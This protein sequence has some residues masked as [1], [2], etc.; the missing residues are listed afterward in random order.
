M[1][2]QESLT[3]HSVCVTRNW[4]KEGAFHLKFMHFLNPDSV[5]FDTLASRNPY[6]SY[7]PGT[8]IPVF[9]FVK[10]S[11]AH[12]LIRLYET[13]NLLN[14]LVISLVLFLMMFMVVSYFKKTSIVNV[15]FSVIPSLIYLFT[16]PTLYWHQ[17]VFFADQAVMML[18]VLF[19]YLELRRFIYGKL[20]WPLEAFSVGLVFLGTLT[21]WLFVF[22]VFVAVILRIFFSIRPRDFRRILSGIMDLILPAVSAVV[23]FLYQIISTDSLPILISKFKA[24]TG[25]EGVR[26]SFFISHF[27]H[28]CIDGYGY[29]LCLS[30]VISVLA[31]LF[32]YYGVKPGKGER[33]DGLDIATA[34]IYLV[35]LTIAPCLLQVCVLREHS[36]IFDFSALKWAFP[37]SLIPFGIFPVVFIDKASSLRHHLLIKKIFVIICTLLVGIG[38]FYRTSV[39]YRSFF[40]VGNDYAQRIGELVRRNACYNDICLSFNFEIRDFPPQCLAYSAKR[41]Y[42]VKDIAEAKDV[43]SRFTKKGARGKIFIDALDWNRFKDDMGRNCSNIHRDSD[44]Y[45]CEI[46]KDKINK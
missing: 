26:T 34:Y 44:Y 40:R 3:A 24:R 23:L 2:H 15:L 37:M 14:H 5:E 33:K 7:P 28:F 43:V 10:I 20:S 32:Y 41:V 46:D 38:V 39:R 18:F 19:A 42:F 12:D 27:Y 1:E 17:N 25:L 6:V 16:P 9:L 30:T 35:Y 31:L 21:D 11:H 22:V 13:Y 45:I 36:T 29:V 4:L 8:F